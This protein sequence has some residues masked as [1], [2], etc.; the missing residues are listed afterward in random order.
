M[1]DVNV[2]AC[3]DDG[4]CTLGLTKFQVVSG[5]LQRGDS[6]GPCFSSASG[7]PNTVVAR[8][9]VVGGGGVGW[10]TPVNDI[11]ATLQASIVTQ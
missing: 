4:T 10:C 8:G 9:Q 2:P 11:S 1:L 3:F 7:R 6:G 5:G